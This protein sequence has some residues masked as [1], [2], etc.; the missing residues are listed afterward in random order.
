MESINLNLIPG[1][2]WP[3]AH[4]SQFDVG[5]VVRINLFEGASVYT[6]DGT[7]TV[8][9]IV[10]KPDGNMV[11]LTLTNTTD[12]YVD[13]VTTE[14]MT[15]CEGANLGE[16]RVEKGDDVIGSLNFILECEKSP[17]TG[18]ESESEIN[19]L[20]T[21]V[22]AIVADQYAAEDVVFDATPTAGHGVGFAVTSE[23][24]K[25]A[26]DAIIAQIPTE[27]DDLSDVTT[28]SPTSGEALVW[29]GSKW[30]NGTPDEDLDDL[31][32][33][34]ITTPT[35]GEI[36]EYDG[37]DWVN[38]PNPASTDNFGAP[39]DENTTYNVPSIVIY[40]NLLYKL[41]DGE[42]GTT[43]TWDPTKWTQTSLAELSGAD[44][45]IGTSS[46]TSTIAGAVGANSTAIATKQNKA[47]TLM[48]DLT[49]T[50]EH[51]ITETWN[52]ILVYGEFGGNGNYGFSTYVIYAHA[53][54]FP[55]RF[56][57]GC[58]NST[59]DQ[60]IAIWHL[61]NN[62]IGLERWYFQGTDYTSTSKLH[63]YYR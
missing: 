55:R 51:T 37:A 1:K 6:L 42:D 27:I 45:P 25:N 52:E 10:K 15:A 26:D 23:G 44:I 14:Q 35:A 31:G 53:T 17:D 59:S 11:T 20:E 48:D 34:A 22:A 28:A 63:I 3:V 16:I 58:S 4:C 29:D 54:G 9:A 56:L 61:E 39:Y 40:N 46:D 50:A 8:T 36:L 33:V 60:H 21:Q 24:V 19:N 32:D 13:L 18:I 30:T 49:G 12:S 41:N 7:E 2:A 47:W 38:V 43:G 5:R 57:E 62:K